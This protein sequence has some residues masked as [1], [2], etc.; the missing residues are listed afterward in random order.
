MKTN[1]SQNGQTQSRPVRS[2]IPRAVTLQDVARAVQ[3]S[4][5]T[6]SQVMNGKGRISQQTRDRVRQVARELCFQPN[7]AGQQLAIGHRNETVALFAMTL[8]SEVAT[9]KLQILQHLLSESGFSTPLYVCGHPRRSGSFNQAEVVRNL[10]LL[11]P[12]AIICNDPGLDQST[13]EELRL[14]MDEGGT[15]VCYDNAVELD[16]D[17]VVFDREHNTY[18]AARHLLELGHR[19]IGFHLGVS[20]R[21][22][23]KTRLAGLQRALDEYNAPLQSQWLDVPD[24]NLHEGAGL[25]LAQRF[26]AQEER[27][28]AMCIV[29]DHT[30]A[31]FLAYVL[32]SGLRVPQDVSIVSH[33]DLPLA[34]LVTTVTL[35]SVSQPVEAIASQ[36]ARLLEE[37]LNGE[38]K[39]AS[40]TIEVRGELL[41]RESSAPLTCNH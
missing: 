16:C 6:V 24:D 1:A 25:R 3:L 11:R 28:T 4:E 39:G 41:V 2:K 26:L 32:R 37:R 33:D 5:C 38:Y 14:F 8:D 12:R 9:Q 36:V 27:P 29:N 23:P 34:S 7:P 20:G 40:R 22:Y 13:L 35:T 10:R 17:Q 21:R 19:R 31:A 18:L 30:A 15:V